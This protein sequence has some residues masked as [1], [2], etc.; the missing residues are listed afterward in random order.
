MTGRELNVS[1]A[2]LGEQKPVAVEIEEQTVVR[3]TTPAG[4]IP[5][6]DGVSCL[7]HLLAAVRTLDLVDGPIRVAVVAAVLTDPLHV[8]APTA[9]S[10]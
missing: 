5:G 4:G 3:V 7:S 1:P 2:H 8:A 6:A 10:W 9:R